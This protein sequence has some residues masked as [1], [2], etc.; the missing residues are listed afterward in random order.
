MT[1]VD[2]LEGTLALADAGIAD[3][4]ISIVSEV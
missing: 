4:M 2:E 1:A 3:E